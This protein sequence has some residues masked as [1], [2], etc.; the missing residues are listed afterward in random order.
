MVAAAAV[1]AGAALIIASGLYLFH[2]EAADGAKARRLR[3]RGRS[4]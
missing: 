1:I 3:R 4:D 2:A